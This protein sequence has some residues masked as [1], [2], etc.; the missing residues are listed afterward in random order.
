MVQIKGFCIAGH[1]QIAES[2]GACQTA[3]GTPVTT[4]AQCELACGKLVANGD[5]Q[6][7]SVV[8]IE[9]YPGCFYY[10]I[11]GKCHWNKNEAATAWVG[12]DHKAVC[13]IG[14]T[15]AHLQPY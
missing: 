9:N 2:A 15:I 8:D 4:E 10:P 13:K 3:D 14:R 6:E 5:V 7:Y 1:F 12:N 11:N